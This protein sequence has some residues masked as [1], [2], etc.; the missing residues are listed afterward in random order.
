MASCINDADTLKWICLILGVR[1]KIAQ[2]VLNGFCRGFKDVDWHEM[3]LSE[4]QHLD[5]KFSLQLGEDGILKYLCSVRV[6]DA[7]FGLGHIE[8]RWTAHITPDLLLV[9]NT[10]DEGLFAI[11]LRI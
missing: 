7:A 4:F 8:T 5:Q 6:L 1:K 11:S 3:T 2:R 10:L 9:R